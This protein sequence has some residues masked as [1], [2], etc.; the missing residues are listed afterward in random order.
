MTLLFD[1]EKVQN[2]FAA[3]IYFNINICKWL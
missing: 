2:K 3:F 1:K